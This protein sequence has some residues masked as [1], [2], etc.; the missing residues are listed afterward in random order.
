MT[1]LEGRRTDA[2]FPSCSLGSRTLQQRGRLGWRGPTALGDLM[3]DSSLHI[4]STL[5]LL[6]GAVLGLWPF[7]AG[8]APAPGDVIKGRVMSAEKIFLGYYISFTR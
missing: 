6:L 2:A 4:A 5:G 7:Q 8:V 1:A 3:E